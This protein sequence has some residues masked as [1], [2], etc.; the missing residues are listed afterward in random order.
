MDTEMQILFNCIHG[1][2]VQLFYRWK[3]FRQL[4]GSGEENLNL[5]NKSGSNVFAL[6]QRLT[7]DNISLTL[8]RLTD[9]ERTGPYENLSIRNFLGR[10]EAVLNAKVREDL[11]GK[12]AKLEAAT[13][14]LRVH[15]SKRIAHLDLSH[16]LKPELLPSLQYGDLQD[17]LKLLESIMR[18]L[19][20]FVFN[21]D[22]SYKEPAVAYGCDGEY[23]LR[24]LRD[25][26]NRQNDNHS[27]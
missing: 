4:F 13:E 9:P 8:C 21:A 5:L 15:R 27:F 22:T 18:D 24:F 11:R 12:L 2:V 26:H 19:H 6:F 7:E 3:I 1:E 10:I 20:L 25:A 14:K 17:A 16:A 23:L